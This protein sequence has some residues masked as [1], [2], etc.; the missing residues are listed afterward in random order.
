MLLEDCVDYAGIGGLTATAMKYRGFRESVIDASVGDTLQI[1]KL[2]R[3]VFSRGIAP[4]TTINH[5]RVTG[6]NVSVMRGGVR[7]NPGDIVTADASREGVGRS[8][9]SPGARRY[10]TSHDSLH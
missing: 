2:Q 3:P 7:M 1:R 8:E 4:S 10:G 9:E 6:V 5:Y